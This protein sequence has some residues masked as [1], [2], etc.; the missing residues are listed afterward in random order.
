MDITKGIFTTPVY[1]GDPEPELVRICDRAEGD[2]INLSVIK[3]CVH[4]GTHV[5]SPSH[6]L[7][8]GVTVEKLPLE[9]FIGPC[10]VIS[11]NGIVS[12][13]LI[14]QVQMDG[15]RILLIKGDVKLDEGICMGLLDKN[16]ATIGVEVETIG[17]GN[18]HR[19]VL[20]KNIAVIE[21]LDLSQI[22]EGKYF[23]F[24]PP[25]KIEGGEGAFVRA[26][27]IEGL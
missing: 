6:Y 22:K 10:K 8:R 13:D 5:D 12:Y 7:D 18:V 3:A 21:N 20:G 26:V 27:L 11:C 15:C 19:A 4:T 2:E 24:A 17:D 25:V 16:I 14:S 9:H 1:P 23:L